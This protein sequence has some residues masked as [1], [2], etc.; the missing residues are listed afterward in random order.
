M[1]RVFIGF[2]FSVAAFGQ[3]PA[4]D[5]ASIKAAPPPTGGMM[6]VGLS[7]G[8]GT[9]DPGLFKCENCSISQLVAQAYDIQR[10]QFSGPS[11][12]DSER[13]DITAKV[14]DGA[15]KEQFRVMLQNLLAERFRMVVHHDRKE[16]AIYDLV[17]AKSGPKLKESA[18][19]DP[20][21][22]SPELPAAP[23]GGPG[24]KM[25]M[26]KDGFPVLPKLPGRPM[27]IMMNGRARS[28]A[29]SV[30]MEDLAKFLGNQVGGKPVVD[31]T[32][33][34][35][36][37]DYTLTFAPDNMGPG[38]MM[39][40]PPG[41]GGEG[42]HPQPPSDAE[43]LPNIFAALQEQLGLKLEPKR[44]MVDLLVVDHVEKSP[45]EN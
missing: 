2:V 11:T 8:P 22:P 1:P 31:A 16:M 14:P 13:F 35:G 37:Y 21:A 33:L 6:R 40:P 36:K 34:K 9:K 42:G 19:V 15:T 41:G 30:T 39:G 24:R 4:F 29:S 5:V 43:P 7:G 3:S 44:G 27:M 23:L 18:P 10:F 32:G 25:E 20:N 45:S 17:I 38:M 12:L 26:D 28:A